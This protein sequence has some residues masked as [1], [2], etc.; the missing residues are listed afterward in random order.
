MWHL[1]YAHLT[2]RGCPPDRVN[3]TAAALIVTGYV[4]ILCG[5]GHTLTPAAVAVV[6]AALLAWK[7]RLAGFS[8]ALTEAELR[9][10]ILLAI[11][12]FVVYPAP[13][14]VNDNETAVV[15]V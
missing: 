12:A 2:E 14:P 7:E 1:F 6:T 5:L 9:S 8:K 3:S 13:E 10:A 4:G 15:R 11:L